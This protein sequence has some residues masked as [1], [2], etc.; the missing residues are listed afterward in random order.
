MLHMCA[1]NDLDAGCGITPPSAVDLAS[2]H[3]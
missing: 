1:I 2:L 3:P